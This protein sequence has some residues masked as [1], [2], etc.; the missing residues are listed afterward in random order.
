MTYGGKT[1]LPDYPKVDI[2]GDRIV[3][4]EEDGA[5]YLWGREEEG[6]I[7]VDI[8]KD[9]ELNLRAVRYVKLCLLDSINKIMFELM[10]EKIPIEYMD[11]II[12][13]G[14]KKINNYFMELN[15]N[16]IFLFE[17]EERY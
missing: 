10:D 7:S 5:E 12:Y 1:A 15:K 4:V 8:V 6:L 14:Y 17:V 2:Q 11:K 13:D 9:I 3:I 16:K